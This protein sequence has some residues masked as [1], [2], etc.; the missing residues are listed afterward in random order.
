L[1]P[2]KKALLTTSPSFIGQSIPRDI[3]R[4][5][6]PSSSDPDWKFN[7]WEIAKDAIGQDFMQI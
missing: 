1:D 3:Y 6:L 5:K 7:L 2:I 4:Q